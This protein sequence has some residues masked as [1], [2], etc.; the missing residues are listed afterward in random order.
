MRTRTLI[1]GI[2]FLLLAVS[3]NDDIVDRPVTNRQPRT[4]L[5][6]YPDS[7]VGIGVSRQRLRWWGEDP[8]GLV[9]GYLFTAVS[10]PGRPVAPPSPDTLR[11]AW[12]SAN[13]TLM[14]FPLD[15]LFRE[16]TVVVRA[17]DN[18]F[19]RVPNGSIIRLTPSPYLDRNDNGRLDG[20][21]EPLN[22]L[23]GAMDP[24]GSLRVFP[25][26]NT[27]P[28]IRFAPDPNDE[29]VTLR[30]P[31]TTY[32][33]ATFAWDGEDDDGNN[34]LSAY[35]IA[36][37][38]TSDPATMLTLAVRETLVTLTVPRVRSDN[39]GAS[40]A[41]DVYG[42]KFLGRQLLGTLPGLLLD[43]ENVLYVQARDVAGEA[44]P[45]I[46]MP[47]NG[48]R[49]FVRRPRGQV[50]LV[51][52]YINSDSVQADL[53]YRNA[54]A[55][56]P[57]GAYATVDRLN[58]GRGLTAAEKKLEKPGALLPAFVDPALIYTFLLYDHVVWYTDQY[59]SLGAAQLSLFTYTQNGGK[60]VFSTTFE[61]SVDARGALRDF[62]PID[63]I[64]S[65]NPVRFPG[66]PP[67]VT[68][69]RLRNNTP[70]LPDTTAAD[71]RYPRLALNATPAFHS[72]FMRPVY[73]RSDA[74]NI[75]YLQADSALYIGH[76][77]IGVVDGLRRTLFI[78]LPLHLMDNR[79]TGNPDGLS[80]FFTRAL[81][82][83]FSAT[84]RINRRKF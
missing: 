36:L 3:C 5:W 63:S 24:L 8:D 22:G 54:L 4:F 49:W 58:I 50:L 17:V 16:Y 26:R 14:A 46:R 80:A 61:S 78:G 47:V 71:V 11:Y 64:S 28:T 10:L 52:D 31:E 34:T 42:G 55:A 83:E 2:S 70:L 60:L 82:Q 18:S 40:V 62:A 29:T 66:D 48:Q 75:Y 68:S 15:T 39:A 6:L 30:Q 21:D 59:P 37:N 12:T 45:F 53:T 1:A 38:D 69:T 9:T 32:T 19:G 57:G 76:P 72:V 79:Q 67:R 33:T 20:G 51:S 7:S 81:L 13:D 41:A 43:A 56:V 74:R 73:R 25:I 23:T 44:S 77:N 65:V 27:P 35:R 84:H